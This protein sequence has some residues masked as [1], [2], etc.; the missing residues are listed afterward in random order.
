MRAAVMADLHPTVGRVFGPCHDV[1]Q[2]ALTMAAVIATDVQDLA[3]QYAIAYSRVALSIGAGSF[4]R[5]PVLAAQER[6]TILVAKVTKAPLFLLVVINL[7]F[8]VMGAML[9]TAIARTSREVHEVQSR[10]SIA[11][12]IANVF[13]KKWA[14][15][16]AE[17]VERLYAEY[18][19]GDSTTRVGI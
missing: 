14:G 1:L 15:R 7:G 13:E 18:W 3:N 5:S 11:G 6:T 9:A 19:E 12:I 17:T 8:V 2:N 10:F 4:V 16:P